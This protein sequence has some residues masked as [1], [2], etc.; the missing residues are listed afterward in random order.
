MKAPAFT[1][2]A[3]AGRRLAA[4][5]DRRWRAVAILLAAVLAAVTGISHAGEAV[6][7]TLLNLRF[8]ARHHAASGKLHLVEIDARSIAAVERWPWPRSNFAVLVDRLHQAGASSIAFDVDFSSRST[9]QEDQAFAAALDRAGGTVILP[10]LRQATG[11]GAAGFIDLMP[12]PE[13]RTHAMAAAVSILPDNAG[14]VRSAP[15]G[16]VTAG[17]PRPSL[18]AIIASRAGAAWQNFPIDYAIDLATI[19]RH[20]FVDMRDGHFDPA[21]IA[22]KDVLVGATAVELGDRYA[23]P[24]YGVVPGVAIQALAAETLMA[25]VPV[26]QGWLLPTLLALAVAWAMLRARSAWILGALGA[27]VPVGLFFMA[28]AAEAWFALYFPIVPALVGLLVPVALAFAVRTVHAWR[29]GRLQDEATGMPNRAA[30]TADLG[31]EPSLLI[32][33]ARIVDY[34]K[35]LAA[36]GSAAVAEVVC[37]VRDRIAT[38][39]DGETVYRIEDRVVAWRATVTLDEVQL[40]CEQLRHTMKLPVEVKGRQVDVT[41]TIGVASGSGA[42]CAALLANAAYAAAEARER[43]TGWHIHATG[44]ADAA[45]LEVTLLGELGHAIDAGELVVH[46]QPKLAIRSGLITSVEALVRWQHP[47]RGLLGPD[48]FIPL[49]E[50]NN[51]IGDLTLHVL[52]RT[53]EALQTWAADG[54]RI[55]GAVNISANLLSSGTF[56]E[57]AAALIGRTGIDPAQLTLEVTESAAMSDRAAA[58]RSLEAIKALGVAISMDDY[59]TGHSTLTYLKQL[60]LDELKLDRSFVQF[61]HQN[62]SDAVLVRS[63]VELAHELGLKVVAEGVEDA[64]CLAY[65]ASIGCD[66]AQGYLISRPVP[67]AAL[68]PLLNGPLSLAA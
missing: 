62:R 28:Q 54:H 65:L 52:E 53:I 17:A 56:L 58:I 59:G 60:P 11:S 9:A 49:A 25:G 14:L 33:T 24:R 12:I 51:R 10:T 23:V 22:G 36:L 13:L 42:E 19:P 15:M 66:M 55:S 37:R 30:M 46:Y 8:G 29:E 63:T 47:T 4:A 5:A 1:G 31:Q 64:A 67:A 34:D 16:I 43:G 3:D 32:A 57:E 61:A 38:L 50:R 68:T 7:Q 26:E 27:L 41:L 45:N 6:E 21:Q 2:L 48:L 44:A 35:L 18:S 20:S 39:S 40:R